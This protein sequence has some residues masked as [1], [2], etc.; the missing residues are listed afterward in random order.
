[1]EK[2]TD[3]QLQRAKA[4]WSRLA[5]TPNWVDA[6]VHHGAKLPVESMK[7]CQSRWCE[8]KYYPG[9][10]VVGGQC[11]DCRLQQL[12]KSTLDLFTPSRSVVA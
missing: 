12:K 5:P 11:F 7:Q 3:L 6:I 10:Y 4:K 9:Y 2:Q 1:M 8:G